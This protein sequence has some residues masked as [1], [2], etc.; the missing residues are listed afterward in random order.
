MLYLHT[1]NHL[2]QLA[3]TLAT[4]FKHSPL[5]DPFARETLLVP[6]K[7]IEKWLVAQ[8]AEKIGVW[9]NGRFLTNL[10]DFWQL[11]NNLLDTSQFEREVMGWT[12]MEILPTFLHHPDFE[13]VTQYLQNDPFQ[14][15]LFQLSRQI[16]N[17]F[18]RYVIYRS[19][20]I[21]CWENHQEN[22]QNEDEKWQANLWR[23]L[24]Q[25]YRTANHRGKLPEI[26]FEQLTKNPDSLH[27]PKRL[28]IFGFSSFPPFYLEIFVALSQ[29][30]DVHLFLLD[31]CQ[32]YWGDIVSD[33]ELTQKTRN[34]KLDEPA[35]L[36][37][38]TGNSLLAS[39]GRIGRDLIDALE[40]FFERTP[41]IPNE[42]FVE[43]SSQ[44]LLNTIQDDILHLDERTSSEYNVLSVD[45]SVQIHVCHS[46]MRE[47][48]ILYDQLLALFEGNSELQ[49]KD[50]IILT[51]DIEIYA[52]F[53]QA[54]FAT[55]TQEQ[56]I[57]P[58]TIVDRNLRYES[59]LV[60][61]F[62]SILALENS[63][64]TV[65]DVFNILESE[66]VQNRFELVTSDLE[67]IK[68]WIN[69]V[70]IRWGMDGQNRQQQQL[71]D[72][73]EN[74]WWFGLKRL[75]LGYAM[76]NSEEKLFHGFLPFNEIEGNEALILG[77][78]IE[79]VTQ[80]FETANA[81]KQMRTLTEWVEFL[82]SVLDKFLGGS[83]EN[84]SQI[85]QLHHDILAPLVTN[86]HHAQFTA[87]VSHHIIQAYLR[88]H[89]EATSLS[90][91]HLTG[92]VTFCAIQSMPGIPFKVVC[93]LGM[94]DHAF[95]RAQQTL[96]FDLIAQQPRRGD[97]SLRL[98]DR[99]LFL[100]TLLAA[101]EYLYISYIGQSIRDNTVLPPSVLVSEL[102]DYLAKGFKHEIHE[103][104][105]DAI[106]IFHPLQP[107]SPRY[108]DQILP[109][110]FS[111]SESYCRAGHRLI[112]SKQNPAPFMSEP[113][114]PPDD[115]WQT[116]HIEQL[117]KFFAHPAKFLLQERLGIYLQMQKI[118]PLETEPFAL[119][120]LEKY[121]F[122]QAL[123][124]K[125]LK[126]QNLSDYQKIAKATGQ[127][128]HGNIG[129]YIYEQQFEK[130][131]HF[132]EKVKPYLEQEK[133][134]SPLINLVLGQ[135][136]LVGHLPHMWANGLVLYRHANLSAKDYLKAWIYH[137]IFNH[138]DTH[139]P[140]QAVLIGK[141][142]VIFYKKV[143]NNQLLLHRLLEI[144]WQGLSEPLHFF[145]EASLNFV[146]T[147]F[148]GKAEEE[149]FVQAKKT[150]FGNDYFPGE[151]EDDY[152]ALCFKYVETNL[153]DRQFV[154]LANTIFEPL[155]FHQ[156]ST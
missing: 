14:I 90:P 4:Y 98:E 127:L 131:Q 111:Y 21:T 123:V 13:T 25:Y 3:T 56:K 8:L 144:Y 153:F 64:F 116:I 44:T 34:H 115:A 122:N 101:R 72:Y 104:I 132:V 55:V 81:L 134:A 147:S 46:P 11:L 42:Y 137:L 84:K 118:L 82:L 10:P 29:I 43:N 152:Y 151:C 57:I 36:H 75:L 100:Q 97:H 37:Y 71:P 88:Q 93:L 26:L 94:N 48:E 53:I 40:T 19:D 38:Q 142:K 85:H 155:L 102:L 121:Y 18:D 113:L 73:E 61:I 52:P 117:I 12:L 1:S 78:F 15:K 5:T 47:V 17:T 149:A 23:G 69:N 107:F 62:L 108:F 30:T 22:Q 124:E 110:L 39:M 32:E 120:N 129:E 86:S 150:W 135:W 31:P 74:T 105:L 76:S 103:K 35:V 136:Q 2:E 70:N 146:Q 133:I 50:I 28:T 148:K 96:S 58:F 68:L 27:L 65:A 20:L 6:N 99:Y 9:A 89:I 7:S 87:K 138:L 83:E 109:N 33:R 41:Y 54:V 59:E 141:D 125:G 79:F 51:P 45:K 80:L 140:Q 95:P 77:K 145:P 119:D 24:I 49:P 106:Q 114:P 92:K 154:D 112:A 16:A 139:I 66:I 91:Y 128:P 63:R 130:T 143:E 156:K 126:D 67:K 60:S